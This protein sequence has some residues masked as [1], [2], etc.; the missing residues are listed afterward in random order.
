MFLTL[1]ILIVPVFYYNYISF[2]ITGK[3]E[4]PKEC[5][6]DSPTSHQS[7]TQQSETKQ[8]PQP[9]TQ[10][11]AVPTSRT[12][13][14]VKLFAIYLCLHVCSIVITLFSNLYGIHSSKGKGDRGKKTSD[15][16]RTWDLRSIAEFQ[17][18]DPRRPVEILCPPSLLCTGRRRLL[19]ST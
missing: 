4:V 7:S 2:Y 11:S 8:Q 13:T 6:T 17:P 19:S 5:K 16:A 1:L 9:V 10:V 18:R 15:R 12:I 14:K 3:N